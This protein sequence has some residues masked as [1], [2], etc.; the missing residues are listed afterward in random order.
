[1]RRS[2]LVVKSLTHGSWSGNIV[3][4]TPPGGGGR[5]FLSINLCCI[6]L[7]G[8][9]FPYWGFP[10]VLYWR[11][12]YF[13]KIIFLYSRI[14]RTREDVYFVCCASDMLLHLWAGGAA[15]HLRRHAHGGEHRPEEH[16]ARASCSLNIWRTVRVPATFPR[17]PNSRGH[18]VDGG[19]F[20]FRS[21]YRSP[22]V[23][24]LTQKTMLRSVAAV[25]C[26]LHSVRALNCSIIGN[27]L[28]H[29]CDSIISA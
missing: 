9:C 5:G 22:P 19:Q 14:G 11:E 1:M 17:D 23:A 26:V 4:R 21:Q 7:G 16:C 27:F 6:G 29:L 12:N 24:T 10:Y 20:V 25:A 2:H 18:F 8:F 28:L 15:H 3:K 13:G